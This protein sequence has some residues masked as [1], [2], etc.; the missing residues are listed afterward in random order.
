M[1]LCD[2]SSVLKVCPAWKY[3]GQH[4]A[5]DIHCTPRQALTPIMNGGLFLH[6]ILAYQINLNVWTDVVLHLARPVTKWYASYLYVP[7]NQY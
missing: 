7:H 1:T 2:Q 5:C 3:S 6:C 4:K